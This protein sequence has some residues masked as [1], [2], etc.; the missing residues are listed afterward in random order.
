MSWNFNLSSFQRRRD[1][2]EPSP[3]DFYDEINL[4]V[5]ELLENLVYPMCIPYPWQRRCQKS[6]YYGIRRAG[7]SGSTPKKDR[8]IAAGFKKLLAGG[9]N[10]WCS[11]Q[12]ISQELVMTEVAAGNLR[13]SF[14]ICLVVLLERHVWTLHHSKLSKYQSHEWDTPETYEFNKLCAFPPEMNKPMAS[15]LICCS[16]SATGVLQPQTGYQPI[17]IPTDPQ[18]IYCNLIWLQN[19]QNWF[20]ELKS[21]RASLPLGKWPSCVSNLKAIW[22]RCYFS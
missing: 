15:L 22:I 16:T 11:P 4:D 5:A 12:K 21:L 20:T 19:W 17:V 3:V 18:H 7:L 2:G 8:K 9:V 14:E 1:W 6:R 10:F 13:S